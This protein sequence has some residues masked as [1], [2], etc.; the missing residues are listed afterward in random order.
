MPT[1]RQL[2]QAPG[3]AENALL[4]IEGDELAFKDP[5]TLLVSTAQTIELGKKQNL[6]FF[7]DETLPPNCNLGDRGITPLGKIYNATDTDT[8]ERDLTAPDTG[9]I[10]GDI[11]RV[12]VDNS[13]LEFVQPTSLPIV[14]TAGAGGVTAKQLVKTANDGSIVPLTGTEGSIGI[15]AN[16]AAANA[17]VEIRTFGLAT[18]VA[19]GATVAGN[20]LISGTTDPSRVK[21]S[22]QTSLSN[23]A[24]TLRV[25]GK[26]LET[27]LDG[28]DVNVFLIGANRFGAQAG[29]SNLLTSRTFFEDFVIFAGSAA[30][31]AGWNRLTLGSSGS[32]SIK[33]SEPG[34]I[35]IVDSLTAAAANSG[36]ILTTGGNVNNSYTWKIDS[37]IGSTTTFQF[38]V[39]DTTLHKIFI[40]FRDALTN[41]NAT[42]GVFFRNDSKAGAANWF[43]VCKSGG[44][45]TAVDLGVGLSGGWREVSI[46]I[47]SVN[48]VTFTFDGG[49][50]VTIT[51]NVPSVVMAIVFISI[52]GEAAGKHFYADNCYFRF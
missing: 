23:I 15:A 52:T 31:G 26:A 19:E 12:K 35:G 6:I 24:S 38:K 5:T 2:T 14:G 8:W 51:T 16:T 28:Q 17:K 25:V 3:Y 34:H 9:T 44:T 39:V 33:A 27:K 50:P 45:E 49:T 41:E 11:L 47:N 37:M 20:Y 4:V 43:A 42:N 40:G 36:N 48:S 10:G 18:A 30:V 29:T 46:K 13:G 22:G 21:D 1:D 32:F 7:P